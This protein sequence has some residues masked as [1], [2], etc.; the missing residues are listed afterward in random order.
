L[1][2]SPIPLTRELFSFRCDSDV[3]QYAAIRA[4]FGIGI[5]QVP[6]AKR[7][8]LT[9]VL[10][11]SVDFSLTTWVV[12]HRDLKNTRRMQLMFDHLAE[13]LRTYVQRQ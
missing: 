1:P 9:Q 7:D 3:G 6:L 11:G 10:A 12:M 5:C 2:E 4:G 13:Q 8:G